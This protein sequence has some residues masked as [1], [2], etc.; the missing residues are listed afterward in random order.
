M[1]QRR[2]IFVPDIDV[3][4]QLL[5]EILADIG[6]SLPCG[7]VKSGP[8]VRVLYV[9]NRPCQPL[10]IL[11]QLLCKLCRTQ[12][13]KLNEKGTQKRKNHIENKERDSLRAGDTLEEVEIP[14]ASRFQELLNL[15]S[16]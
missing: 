8:L 13:R 3:Q 1:C 10:T 15:V 7:E 11:V 2:T 12:T 6:L 9:G 4:T 5:D 16:N 14:S